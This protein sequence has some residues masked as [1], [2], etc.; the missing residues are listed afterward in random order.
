LDKH[1]KFYAKNWHVHGMG[2]QS[3]FLNKDRW[4]AQTDARTS[5]V[6]CAISAAALLFS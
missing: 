5:M 1:G 2:F 4:L 6:V 3:F